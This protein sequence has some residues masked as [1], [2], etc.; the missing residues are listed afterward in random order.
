MR[1]PTH[2]DRLDRLRLALDSSRCDALL[3]T[4][5]PNVFYL[6]GFTGSNAALLVFPDQVHLFTDGRYTVQAR[7]EAPVARV[8]IGRQAPAME[9]AQLILQRK[10][11]GAASA[12]V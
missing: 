6:C 5:L 4:H 10:Q 1:S 11:G 9:A 7:Q 3:V 8:H 2:T 12:G